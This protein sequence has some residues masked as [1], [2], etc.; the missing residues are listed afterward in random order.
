MA[1]LQAKDLIQGL[2]ITRARGWSKLH[3]F[4][5]QRKDATTFC[6]KSSRHMTYVSAAAV[7]LGKGMIDAYV[8]GRGHSVV[9]LAGEGHIC[10]ECS[11]K[12][13]HELLLRR[14]NIDID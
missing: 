6:G 12:L 2:H 3:V 10:E 9:F 14:S 5:G 13:A 11:A 4:V 7:A 1:Y 8:R